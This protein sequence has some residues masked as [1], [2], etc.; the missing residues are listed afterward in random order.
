MN[1]FERILSTINAIFLMI[2]SILVILLSSKLVS[3]QTLWTRLGLLYGR[4]E[5]ILIGII[6]LSINIKFLLSG[7]I[8]R[9]EL[10]TT[11]AHN[12]LGLLSISHIALE[13]LVIKVVNN[14]KEIKDIKVKIRKQ[15]EGLF[16]DLKLILAPENIVVPELLSDLQKDIKEYIEGTVGVNVRK[17]S[18]KIESVETNP[19][20]HKRTV[21]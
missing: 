9:P 17:I 10:L 2:L 20:S 1:L 19:I 6:L 13:K 5:G 14:I 21:R 12:E 15:T 11:I 7:I 16:I 3:L 8:P 18:I 4:W